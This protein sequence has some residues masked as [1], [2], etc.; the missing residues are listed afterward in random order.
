MV[1][2]A[3]AVALVAVIVCALPAAAGAQPASSA[4]PSGAVTFQCGT[5]PALVA[6]QEGTLW[7]RV[8][9]VDYRLTQP[10]SA[11]GARYVTTLPTSVEFWNRGREATLTI[12]GRTLPTCV[13]VAD[14]RVASVYTARGQEPGWLL[15]IGPDRM[16]LLAAYGE[17]RIET[18]VPV[19][20][21]STGGF[22]YAAATGVGML[23][24]DV[25]HRACQDAM[26]GISYPDTVTVTFGGVTLR[27]CGG[28][29]AA[30]LAGDWT[31][32]R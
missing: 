12:G 16:V 24:V 17:T 27:G 31:V 22:T 21:A 7:L 25:S 29:Q 8:D 18:P 30:A 1:R 13:A 26:S 4:P 19:R 11:S 15:T 3:S 32:E 9:G 6:F 10:A 5:T 28:D 2:F 14:D 20:Q 23:R